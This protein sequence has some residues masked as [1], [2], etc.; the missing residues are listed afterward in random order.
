MAFEMPVIATRISGTVDVIDHEKDGILIPPED[1]EAL[2]NAMEFIIKNPEK[3]Y[4]LGKSA[5]RK[6]VEEFSLD[7]IANRYSE[8]YHKLKYH[9]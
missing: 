2:A 1:P 5:R 3:S 9:A 4:Q 6:V 7:E 8:L